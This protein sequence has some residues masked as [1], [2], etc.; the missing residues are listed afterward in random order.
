MKSIATTCDG[1]WTRTVPTE[2]SPQSDSFL[3]LVYELTGFIVTSVGHYTSF[4]FT[5]SPSLLP[6]GV[7]SSPS[8][9]FF[10]HVSYYVLYFPLLLRY[11]PSFL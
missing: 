3:R 2:L 4:A 8:F 9:I 11:L 6:D 5:P 10:S 1:C 7:L